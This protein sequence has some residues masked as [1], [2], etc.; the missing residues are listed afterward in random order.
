[1]NSCSLSSTKHLL[2]PVGLISYRMSTES[3][4]LGLFDY[5]QFNTEI[6]GLNAE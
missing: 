6:G 5:I 3:T 2:V 1:V 4:G